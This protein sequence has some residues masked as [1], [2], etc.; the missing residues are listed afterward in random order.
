M[1]QKVPIKDLL[2]YLEEKEDTFERKNNLLDFILEHYKLLT[3]IS[4]TIK[5][6]FAIDNLCF[7]DYGEISNMPLKEGILLYN[8]QD[9]KFGIIY[10][11]VSEN[12]IS[13]F[14]LNEKGLIFR[15]NYDKRKWTKWGALSTLYF[16][17]N[18]EEGINR[19]LGER[20]L[21]KGLVGK[22]VLLLQQ[23]L[24]LKNFKN[25]IVCGEFETETENAVKMY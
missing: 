15:E 2:L 16:Y 3:N 17:D 22:D 1:I 10:N 25:L 20:D 21:K 4:I 6:W 19:I 5:P 14:T 23:F 18:Y 24:Q 9:K 11:I 12:N 13:I 7:C 8:I